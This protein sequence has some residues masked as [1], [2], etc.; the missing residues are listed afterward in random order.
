MAENNQKL[1]KKNKFFWKDKLN[2]KEYKIIIEGKTEPAFNNKY[3]D[4]F[5]T[6]FYI[7]RNCDN[8]LFLSDDKFDSQTGWPSFSDIFSAEAIN[9]ENNKSSSPEKIACHCSRCGGHLGHVFADGPQPTGLRYCINSASLHF[10]KNAYL[11]LGC[12][13]GPDAEFGARPGVYFTASG[14]AGGNMNNPEYHNLG[15][16]TETVRISYDPEIINFAEL[17]EIF[18]EAHNPLTRAPSTQYRSIIFYDSPEQ[19]KTAY[20]FW[21]QKKEAAD[22]EVYTQIKALKKYF[23]AEDYH[24]NYF[25]QQNEKLKEYFPR[26]KKQGEVLTFSSL[27]TRLNAYCADFLDGESVKNILEKSYLK[28]KDEQLINEISKSI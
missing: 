20:H 23:E 3:Y 6:G 11:A 27:L 13:W 2:R 5:E 22:S 16:H 14:Y 15:D 12:F 21:E 19:K 18:W 7:C 9:T 25:V 4:H 10:L 26:L 8:P 28:I 1:I 24:Q 17:L